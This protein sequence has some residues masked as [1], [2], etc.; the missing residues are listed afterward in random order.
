M[1]EQGTILT[2]D[3]LKLVVLVASLV[4]L[5]ASLPAVADVG[6]G[7]YASEG[8]AYVF[9]PPTHHIVFSDQF[10]TSV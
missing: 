8:A 6:Y 10:S 2:G 4:I 1:Q 9:G 7:V 5:P 3:T